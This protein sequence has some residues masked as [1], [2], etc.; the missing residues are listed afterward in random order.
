MAAALRPTLSAGEQL[1]LVAAHDRFAHLMVRTHARWL[2]P[3]DGCPD[4]LDALRGARLGLVRAAARFEPARGL[5]F[6]TLAGYQCRKG[7]QA[8]LANRRPRGYRGSP[9]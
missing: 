7:V 1:A 8:W 4:S 9:A 2:R 5:S 6:L 3:D